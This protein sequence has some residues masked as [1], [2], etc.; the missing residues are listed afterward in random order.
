MRRSTTLV[1]LASAAL[2]SSVASPA[3]AQSQ[4]GF[5]PPIYS[6]DNETTYVSGTAVLT[7][8]GDLTLGGAI[9]F[10][11][12]PLGEGPRPMLGVELGVGAFYG[13]GAFGL[14]P[15]P[16]VGDPS[17][18]LSLM[19]ITFNPVLKVK[20]LDEDANGFVGLTFYGG[21]QLASSTM[22]TTN[23]FGSITQESLVLGGLG[24]GVLTLKLG[25]WVTLLG[26][27]G[28]QYS[29]YLAPENSKGSA[30]PTYGGNAKIH[31]TPTWSLDVG[32]TL[33]QLLQATGDDEE[34]SSVKM[35]MVGLTWSD[36]SGVSV[37]E[38]GVLP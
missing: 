1:L 15:L 35:F 14:A 16:G 9:L 12:M 10:T 34:R 18:D 2:G 33:S 29:Y 26:Y 7:L 21:A 22:F 32:S 6:T 28:A 17:F 23:D 19:M 27:G 25:R 37:H 20:V 4:G 5:Q 13:G 3:H 38:K 31:F 24:G 30:F 8:A 36:R 11:G